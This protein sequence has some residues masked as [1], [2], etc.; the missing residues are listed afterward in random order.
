MTEQTFADVSRRLIETQERERGRIARELHDDTGQR[1]VLLAVELDQL[2][3]D[4]SDLPE[5]HSRMDELQKQASEIAT[6][7]QTL[8]HDLNSAKLEQLDLVDAMR[9]PCQELGEQTKVKIEFKTQDLP[10]PLPPDISLWLFRVLRGA[11]RNAIKHS[12]P[13]HV[14]VGLRGRR[15]RFI[16]R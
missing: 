10:S 16:S 9:S 3:Q 8:L 5:V 1:F 11:L 14:E 15:M 2:D 7:I 12:R 6:D 13:Q 4:L